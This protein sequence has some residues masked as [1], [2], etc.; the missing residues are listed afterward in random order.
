MKID[1]VTWG[2]DKGAASNPLERKYLHPRL[3]S[4]LQTNLCLTTLRVEDA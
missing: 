2:T 4:E 1:D 3:Y